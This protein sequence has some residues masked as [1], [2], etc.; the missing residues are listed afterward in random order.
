MTECVWRL[1]AHNYRT[2]SRARILKGLGV[3]PTMAWAVVS[4]C[5]M[6]EALVHVM[7]RV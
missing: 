4:A 3:A 6:V 1:R 7:H 5:Q 2:H